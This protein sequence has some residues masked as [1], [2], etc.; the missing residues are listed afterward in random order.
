MT[1]HLALD[2]NT[3]T[4]FMHFRLIVL[5]LQPILFFLQPGLTE[6]ES[7]GNCIK[8]QR[9][10]LTSLAFMHLIHNSQTQFPILLHMLIIQEDIEFLQTNIHQTMV[11]HIFSPFM[12]IQ[13]HNFAV[14]FKAVL[15]GVLR[16]I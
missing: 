2:G 4:P 8:L 9:R 14:I 16:L 1:E 13:I 15:V 10:G 6:T 7:H 12:H 3:N 5:V 11:G